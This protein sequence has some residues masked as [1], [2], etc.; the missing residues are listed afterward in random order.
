[1][2]Y[3]PTES[4]PANLLTKALPMEQFRMLC[5]KITMND[6][7]LS[8]RWPVDAYTSH[9]NFNEMSSASSKQRALE[10]QGQPDFEILCT[11]FHV[12]SMD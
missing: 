4:Q 12:N 7:M 11:S 9:V 8:L 1:M 2:R 10:K 5:R 3:V 6:S